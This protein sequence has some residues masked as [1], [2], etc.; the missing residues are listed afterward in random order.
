MSVLFLE[1]NGHEPETRNECARSEQV[2]ERKQAKEG[3]KVTFPTGHSRDIIALE[4]APGGRSVP[5]CTVI[6]HWVISG[7]P[8]R[9]CIPRDPANRTVPFKTI[10]VLRV[11]PGRYAI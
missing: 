8:T 5:L 7:H 4:W 10:C 1:T 2:Y 9:G 11:R 6:L 3:A